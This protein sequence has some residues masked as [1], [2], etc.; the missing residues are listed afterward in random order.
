MNL[1]NITQVIDFIKHELMRSTQLPT[2]LDILRQYVYI[3]INAVSIIKKI[4][5]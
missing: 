5:F 4:Q 1:R 3:Y 2:H